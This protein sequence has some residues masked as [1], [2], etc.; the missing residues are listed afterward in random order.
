MA[1]SFEALGRVLR[2]AG[3]LAL[4]RADLAAEEMA[5]ARRRW[6]GWAAAALVGLA[7]LALAAITGVA[8]LTLLLWERFGAGTL[9][10]LAALFALAGALL[11]YAVMHAARS[12]PSPLAQTRIALQEDYEALAAAARAG[13]Q[14]EPER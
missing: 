13:R 7:L 6:V 12:A 1:L 5:L 8:W 11:L 4:L 14:T 10:V 3:Q 9:G 2:H